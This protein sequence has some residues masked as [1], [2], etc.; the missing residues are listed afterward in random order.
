MDIR[1]GAAN[2][3][4]AVGANTASHWKKGLEGFAA[5]KMALQ[6]GDLDTAKAAFSTLHVPRSPHAKSP[7]ARVGQALQSGD[8]AAAQQ[9]LQA[10]L[11]ARMSH[12]H[13]AAPAAE[14]A[15][16]PVTVSGGINLLA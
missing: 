15:T 6:S 13:K 14:P 16:P 8:V 2:R 1:T 10:L 5:L 3:V 9:T 4:S 12:R 7:L 11:E